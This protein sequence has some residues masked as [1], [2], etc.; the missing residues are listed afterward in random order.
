MKILVATILLIA[1]IRRLQFSV[2][3]QNG[4]P[5]R[6]VNGFILRLMRRREIDDDGHVPAVLK[7]QN[8]Q[9]PVQHAVRVARPA[10]RSRIQGGG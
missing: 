1:R 5:A 10:G 4:Q 3:A 6:K 2:T 8:D 7:L 9:A